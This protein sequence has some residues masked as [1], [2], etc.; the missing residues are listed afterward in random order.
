MTH[1]L[2]QI[3]A[4]MFEITSQLKH[5]NGVTMYDGG[6]PHEHVFSEWLH[7]GPSGKTSRDWNKL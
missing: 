3:K 6:F 7:P 1:T 5:F 4:D 2:T